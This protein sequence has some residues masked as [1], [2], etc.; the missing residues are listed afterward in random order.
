MSDPRCVA[1]AAALL[2][3]APALT[4]AAPAAE[5]EQPSIEQ[6]R[7]LATSGR[8]GE[9]IQMLRQRLALAPEDGDARVLLGTVLSWNHSYDE[10]RVELEAVLR[11]NATHSDAVRA[12]I[13]VET[14]ADHPAR[15]D[16]L[17]REALAREPDNLDLLAAR[18]KALIALRELRD[19]KVVVGHMLTLDRQN[20]IAQTLSEQVDQSLRVWEGGVYYGYDL[21]TQEGRDHW[22]W[23]E[24]VAAVKRRHPRGSVTG[25]V[26]VARRWEANDCQLELEAYPKLWSGAYGD[27][28]VAVRPLA[29]SS[30]PTYRG[31]ADLYQVV[32][33]G[34]EA[35]L[36]FRRLQFPA[37][38]T[39]LL[40]ASS[41]KYLGNWLFTAKTF[42]T[43]KAH[44]NWSVHGIVRRYFGDR[45]S[46]LAL[47]YGYGREGVLRGDARSA[48]DIIEYEPAHVVY[49]ELNHDFGR[50]TLNVNF[51]V[52]RQSNLN[53]T[54]LMQYSPNV[55]FSYVF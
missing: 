46:Y 15:V 23:H 5:L 54:T 12:L 8:R 28:A 17:A 11:K 14:W 31:A 42:V 6:A 24:F 26:Y 13:N 33:Q 25:R 29:G 1:L 27:V 4:A 32:G 55:G 21:F 49:T 18:A 37:S 20:R 9:A 43:A 50:V 40:V 16:Q 3:L 45:S 51:A 2:A 38:A 53:G 39:N 47:R 22:D 30:Y 44:P 35:Q 52:L 41:S 19:A 34:F 36:G 48:S 10:A 7:T